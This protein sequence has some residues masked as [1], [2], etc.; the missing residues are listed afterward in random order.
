MK[1]GA[2]FNT[3]AGQ[4]FGKTLAQVLL[5]ETKDEPHKLVRYRILLPTRRACR[6]LRECFLNLSDGKPMLLPQMTPLGDV[7]EEDLS[8]MMFGS[9]GSF[10]DIPQSI[11]PLK[12]QLLLA[13]LI[14]KMPDFVQGADFA[15]EL[16]ADLGALL[17]RITTEDLD[18]RD[19]HKIVPDDFAAHWQI[20]LKFLQI[21]SEAWPA[22]LQEMNVVD[23]ATRRRMLIHALA[24][25]W[26]NNP[27]DTPVI[28]AGSTGSIPATA[29]LLRVISSLPSGR[30]VLPGLDDIMD[31]Q[32]WNA[33]TESHP[34][35]GLK[36]LLHNIGVPR[37]HVKPLL[38]ES[39]ESSR[40]ILASEIMRPAATT[41]HWKAFT[42]KQSLP[43]LLAGIEYYSCA[44]Q[45]EEAQIIS[46]MLRETLE[47]PEKAAALI[48]PD[49][50]LARRV[51]AQCRRWGIELDD[52][53][54]RVL[55]TTQAGLFLI[56][57]GNTVADG[58]DPVALLAMMKH[59]LCRMGYE[60]TTYEELLAQ[61]ESQLLRT[62]DP[63][64][65]FDDLLARAKHTGNSKIEKFITEIFSILNPLLLL[66]ERGREHD[67]HAIM[68][69]HIRAA[70]QCA[71]CDVT[72]G[73]ENMW[74]GDDGE[75]AALFL[76]ELSLHGGL[77][78]NMDYRNYTGVLNRLMGKVT[79]RSPYGSHPRLLLLGQLEARLTS[80]DLII[81][82]GL[83]EGTW[84]AVAA[85][86]PW[87][88]R[89]MK[90]NF[91]LPADE[92]S[93][94]LAAHD[95]VQGFCAGTVVLT[96]AERVDGTP[97]V[98]SRWL[99]RLDTVMRSGGSSLDSL[100]VRPLMR[101]AHEIDTPPEILPCSRPAPCPPVS[102]RPAGVSITKIENWVKDPYAIY[103]RYVLNL[104]KTNPLR[105]KVDAAFKGDILHKALDRFV[106]T[107]PLYLPED[108]R[109]QLLSIGQ[110]I[111]SAYPAQKEELKYW[112]PRFVR[113]AEWFVEHEVAWRKDAKFLCSE[114]KG[115]LDMTTNGRSF[116]LYGI[117][118]RIDRMHGGY[119]LIDY[120]SGGSYSK[121][122]MTSG[123]LPQ[124]P[125]EAMIMARGQFGAKSFFGENDEG[126]GETSAQK[127]P[128]GDTVYMGYWKITGG[129]IAGEEI[130]FPDNL[131]E[132]IQ[133]VEQG[134]QDFLDS[135]YGEQPA[136]FLALPNPANVP[137]FNDY[138]HLER[139]KEWAALDDDGNDVTE[140]AA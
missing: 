8:L 41:D 51:Q 98:P 49:R 74:R 77:L 65:G 115:H 40:R 82:G 72:G 42:Q 95:F 19:L 64:Q 88:S 28:A 33:M 137:H 89:Q 20:T 56:L 76:S 127:I 44:T 70:E 26:E 133:T 38:A 57:T 29:R 18:I 78:G 118:D 69:T 5:H 121:T 106:K 36:T 138:E 113:M 22:I 86:D 105:R 62:R 17:D 60:R 93:V 73:A 135:F 83:N 128:N 114:V 120:K 10:L 25:H 116:R 111:L 61:T 90:K 102:A 9:G 46:L 53:A 27:P 75:A 79:V 80:A 91:G 110:D 59:P 48:T 112:W 67:F 101:W 125:L 104:Q 130:S 96:R 107:Y 66:A 45:Q 50:G 71:R 32:S 109:E 30:L 131:E 108:A 35:W 119:A 6:V 23:V 12:R 103:A 140:D 94:G 54:G 123:S 63:V 136:A 68:A 11:P 134:L 37:E 132:I 24:D 84:P 100:A 34:Q 7:E 13:Q 122:G 1:D 3:R 4:D 14:R 55:T 52:S 124:L 99:Q 92:K 21:I 97:T 129:R 87:M 117:A 39:E 15:L 47:Q 43:S 85:H 81:M 16:A 58:Y 139:V 126:Q 31:D 2:V